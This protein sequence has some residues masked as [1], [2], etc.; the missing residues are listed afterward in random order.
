MSTQADDKDDDLVAIEV[1]DRKDGETHAVDDQNAE[2]DGADDEEDAKLVGEDDDL[3]RDD[4][5]K[6]NREERQR[7][8]DAQKR[9]RERDKRRLE[10]LTNELQRLREEV[11]AV[12]G[13]TIG[14]T[15]KA[16]ENDLSAA[17]REI[18]Q[19]EYVIARALEEGNATDV[20][21]AMRLR[22][23]AKAKAASLSHSKSQIEQQREKLTQPR[24]ADPRVVENAKAWMSANPWYAPNGADDASRVTAQ[25]DA[26]LV[27]EGYDPA[28]TTYWKELSERVQ[29]ELNDRA[30]T[31]RKA[32][33]VRGNRES[34]P[35]TSRKEVYV[36]PERKQAMIEAGAW[37]DPV[38]RKEM[39]KY[40]RD[41]DLKN[42]AR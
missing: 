8:K 41:Y 14:H 4:R 15:V 7:K 39:L 19:A 21:A 38:A 27:R 37:D 29:D 42:P 1:E 25:I 28:S 26:E 3:S 17:Q 16:A 22:D 12:R 20:V 30:D 13:D 10:S 23:D 24:A 33:P 2:D 6:R 34:V 36:T 31:K 9:A 40:Y 32:P 5:N 11:T 18:E 35:S